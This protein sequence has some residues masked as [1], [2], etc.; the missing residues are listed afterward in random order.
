MSQTIVK[1]IVLAATTAAQKHW[2]S[3]MS[4]M[5]DGFPRPTEKQIVAVFQEYIDQ[6]QN[7]LVTDQ[8][9]LTF[10]SCRKN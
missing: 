9:I 4:N 1:F 3:W 5:K 10:T 6:D 2:A 8:E 7:G